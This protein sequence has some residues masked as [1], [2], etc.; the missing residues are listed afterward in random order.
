MLRRERSFS[1]KFQK[2][3]QTKIDRLIKEAIVS[4]RHQTLDREKA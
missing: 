4:L 3:K 1:L 2:L